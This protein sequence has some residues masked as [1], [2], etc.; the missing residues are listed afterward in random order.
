MSNGLMIYCESDLTSSCKLC[1]F[2]LNFECQ[3]YYHTVLGGFCSLPISA[4]VEVVL[5]TG[6]TI[7]ITLPYYNRFEVN[8]LNRFYTIKQ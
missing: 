2:F 4:A 1:K 5:K 8:S 7:V 6:F 3:I